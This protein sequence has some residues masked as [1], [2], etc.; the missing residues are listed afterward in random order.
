LPNAINYRS[1]LKRKIRQNAGKINAMEPIEAYSAFILEKLTSDEIVKL[2]CQWIEEG[3]ESE[4]LN[5]L[6]GEIDPI[7]SNVA[8]LF[9][10]VMNELGIHRLSRLNSALILRDHY[11]KK[12]V[13]DKE[14]VVKYS[15]NI[16]W[17][18]HHEIEEEYPDKAYL[19]D[20]IEIEYICLWLREYWDANDGS[21]L[22]YHCDLPVDQAK[23][24]FKEHLIEEAEKILMQKED[25]TKSD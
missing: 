17:N 6:A 25:Q 7:M 16:Y 5:V 13:T 11:L 14:N 23:E 8:P 1:P 4:T 12:M 10:K 22:L 3:Y 2:S 20:N 21:M 15:E 18:I 9:E 24:K 19:G